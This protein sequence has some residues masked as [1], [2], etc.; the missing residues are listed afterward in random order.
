MSRSRI[1]RLK[2]NKFGTILEIVDEV[3][4]ETV[5]VR[6]KTN[7]IEI[8][9]CDY[10]DFIRGNIISPYDRQFD[11]VGYLGIGQCNEKDNKQ[12]FK[13]FQQFIDRKLYQ[14]NED[15]LDFQKF[16]DF[17]KD[18]YYEVDRIDNYGYK[19]TM[20]I[21]AINEK[22]VFLPSDIDRLIEATKDMDKYV[23]CRSFSSY[24]EYKIFI[25]RINNTKTKV[26]TL[27]KYDEK[28]IEKIFIS[29]LQKYIRNLDEEFLVDVDEDVKQLI[30]NIELL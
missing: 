22:L 21:N 18:N 12:E 7:G 8:G 27:Y 13:Y 26:E 5:I 1:G 16:C 29:E 4:K 19:M 11:K 15:L 24:D 20:K 6:D 14:Y 30:R 2:S 3:D 9:E 10:R 17:F 28:Q 25:P 23:V